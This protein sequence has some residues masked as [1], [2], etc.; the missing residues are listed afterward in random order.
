[1]RDL[2]NQPRGL[3]VVAALAVWT[4]GWH[5]DSRISDAEGLA[6]EAYALAETAQYEADEAQE[7]AEDAASRLDTLCWRAG[8]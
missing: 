6:E 7:E 2:S 1:M 8:C 5:L 4:I 3:W